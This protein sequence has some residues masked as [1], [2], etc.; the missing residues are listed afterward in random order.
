MERGV[1]GVGGRGGKWTGGLPIPQ[2]FRGSGD[3]REQ[4][5]LTRFST[6]KHFTVAK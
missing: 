6:T 5:N 2:Q 1:I 4:M 3:R